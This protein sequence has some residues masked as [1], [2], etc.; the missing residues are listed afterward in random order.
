MKLRSDYELLCSNLMNR[1]PS[2]SLDVCFSELIREE[3]RRHSQRVLDQHHLPTRAIEVAFAATGKLGNP[4]TIQCYSCK[5]YRHIAKDCTKQLCNYCKKE[6]HIITNCRRR[7]QNRNNAKA[8]RA[9]ATETVPTE[10]STLL[11]Y[12][13][14]TSSSSAPTFESIQQ[15]IVQTLSSMGFSGKISFNSR[16]WY[17]DSG[18]SNHMTG[19]LNNLLSSTPYFGPLKISTIDGTKLPINAVSNINSGSM[20]F[21]DVFFVPNLS[22]NL[23]SIGQIIEHNC[24]VL[25]SPTGCII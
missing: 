9:T 19:T 23:L 17:L 7:P 22:T 21:K 2:P 8:Y 4:R 6:G 3:Q 15:M 16:I 10:G 11:A 1:V 13:V 5:E 14:S 18:A 24:L 20:S 12:V 25:F